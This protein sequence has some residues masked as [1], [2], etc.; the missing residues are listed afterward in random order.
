MMTFEQIDNIFISTNSVK[1][2]KIYNTSPKSWTVYTPEGR[3]DDDINLAGPFTSFEEA[4][5]NAE[6]KVGMKV[7]WMEDF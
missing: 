5:R 3:L 7:N 1:P 6:V 4:R 2:V